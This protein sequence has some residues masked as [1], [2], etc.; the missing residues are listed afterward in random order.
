MEA[1]GKGKM[2]AK[3]VVGLTTQL[4]QPPSYIRPSLEVACNI[5]SE[6][7]PTRI[8]S[9]SM[10]LPHTTY[11]HAHSTSDVNLS[12]DSASELGDLL[13]AIVKWISEGIFETSSAD[14]GFKA[15][16][17]T[18]I[19]SFGAPCRTPTEVHTLYADTTFYSA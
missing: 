4:P 15:P 1:T 18:T 3:E 16:P 5:A 7:W 9:R 8:S 13:W 11:T 14:L 12:A 2:R 10:E 17:G 19:T 6:H